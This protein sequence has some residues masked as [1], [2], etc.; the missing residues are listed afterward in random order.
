[1]VNVWMSRIKHSIDFRMNDLHILVVPINEY[2][3]KAHINK[4]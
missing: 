3:N 2:V 1:M 4:A